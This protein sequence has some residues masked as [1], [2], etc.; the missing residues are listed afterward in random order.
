MMQHDDEHF[1][2]PYAA[3]QSSLN[4]SNAI[5]DFQD[6]EFSPFKSIWI[7]PRRTVRRIVAENPELPASLAHWEACSAFGLRPI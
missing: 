1:R 7:H 4:A 2:N 3:P 5:Q 6:D